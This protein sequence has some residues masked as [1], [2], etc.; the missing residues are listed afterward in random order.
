MI[1]KNRII[2]LSLSITFIILTGILLFRFTDF[3]NETDNIRNDFSILTGMKVIPPPLPKKLDFAGEDVPLNLFYVREAL[4]KELSINTYWQSQ[5]LLLFKRANRYLPT[6]EAILKKQGIPEDFKYVVLAESGFQHLVS[7]AGAAGYWQF[8]KETAI[9]YG[10]EV[11][12]Q[13]DERY[14]LEK[15]TN[16]TCKFLKKSYEKY[17]SW[18][19]VGASFNGGQGRIERLVKRQRTNN[20]Y[21]LFMNQE[22]S[23]YIFRVLAL[24]LIFEHPEKYGYQLKKENLYPSIPHKTI[25]ITETIPN[26]VDFAKDKDINYRMLRE[27]NPWLADTFLPV[28]VGKVYKL[29]I[30]TGKFNDYDALL[31][32]EVNGTNEPQ[33]TT[34]IE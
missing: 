16:A 33:T 5:S 24:K 34:E 25:T 7:P 32:D 2:Y 11:T 28:K 15:A 4:D 21:E 17:G 31:R 19:L 3:D 6:V 26:L 1:R 23:R 22:T 14:H 12:D 30:P 9:E 27:L 18:T 13:V 29:K 8:I 10:L 20:Y